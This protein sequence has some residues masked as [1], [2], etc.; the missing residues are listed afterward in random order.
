MS[1]LTKSI[2]IANLLIEMELLASPFFWRLLF[3]KVACGLRHDITYGVARY[4]YLSPISN[5][6]APMRAFYCAK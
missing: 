2:L 4:D 6:P 1:I 5:K 3:V